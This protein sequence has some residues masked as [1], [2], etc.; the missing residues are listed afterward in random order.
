MRTSVLVH[1]PICD[2]GTFREV[3]AKEFPHKQRLVRCEGCRLVRLF[4]DSQSNRDYW[5][6]D[7]TALDVYSNDHVRTELRKR[8][9]RYLTLLTRLS[10]QA[11]TLLDA[12]CGIGN[13]LLAAREKGREVS[14]TELSEKA[15]RIA[16]ERGLNV[17]TARLEESRQ[18]V[19]AFD[20]VTLWD[21]I[22]HLEEPAAAMHVVH[23][24]LRPGGTVFLETPDEGFWVRSALR[25]AFAVSWGRID[26]LRYFYYQ[27]HR[28]YF[29]AATLGQLLSKVGFQNVRVW[30]DVTS[31][32]K[33]HLK[34]APW[35]FPLCGL[36]IPALPAFLGLM[37]WMG[38]GNK[39]IVTA[40]KA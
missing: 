27:D 28:F 10:G 9:Q 2:Q 13:F 35:R 21:I 17:E 23:E 39:L 4:G 37:R 14:G 5:D 33:A 12:G 1:C 20:V 25:G 24:K 34:L 6:E 36:V 15:S 38:L 31:P 29:T 11:G 16:R 7:A 3:L 19:G 22:E 32:T 30:R 40:T 18:P 8:Y 26:L